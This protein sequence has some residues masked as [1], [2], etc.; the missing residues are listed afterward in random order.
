MMLF[1]YFFDIEIYLAER[2]LGFEHVRDA[3]R[4]REN[5]TIEEHRTTFI[6]SYLHA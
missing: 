1:V 3:Q 5:F 4:E 6:H 2:K